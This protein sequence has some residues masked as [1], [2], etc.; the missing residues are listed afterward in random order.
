MRLCAL[1]SGSVIDV[2]LSLSV[3]SK[4]CRMSERSIGDRRCFILTMRSL[5]C[6]FYGVIVDWSGPS[7]VQDVCSTD[8][9]D[10]LA[11]QLNNDIVSEW[12]TETKRSAPCERHLP[13]GYAHKTSTNADQKLPRISKSVDRWYR[14]WRA[15][16]FP[17]ALSYLLR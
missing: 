1:L 8:D 11:K 7:L 5:Q 3:R 6:I 16:S 12:E 14:G 13:V 4:V 10:L 15:V 2:V 17:P 9:K